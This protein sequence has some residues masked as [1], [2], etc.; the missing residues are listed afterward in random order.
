MR[1]LPDT[2]ILSEVTTPVPD[3]RVLEWLDGLDEDSSFIG[4]VSIAEIRRGVA[5]MNPGRKRETPT[6]WLAEELP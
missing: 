2:Y 1:L 4:V 5:P 6:G 3:E